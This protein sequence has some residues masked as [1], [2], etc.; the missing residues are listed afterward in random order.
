MGVTKHT[1]LELTE[2]ATLILA[3]NFPGRALHRLSF[4]GQ[5]AVSAAQLLGV[6]R[7][8]WRPADLVDRLALGAAGPLLARPRPSDVH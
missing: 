3:D 8:P 7:G 4:L 1:E 6:A 5:Q 2:R